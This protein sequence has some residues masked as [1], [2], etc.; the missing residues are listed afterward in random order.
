MD[1]WKPTAQLENLKIRAELLIKIRQFFFERNVLEVETPLLARTTATDVHIQSLEV[2]RMGPALDAIFYLQTSPEFAMKRMLAAGSGAIYQICK[3]FRQ[4]EVSRTHNPEFT[5]LEW[6]QPGYSQ[7]DLINEVESLVSSLLEIQ[8]IP[9]LSY[10]EVFQQQLDFDPHNITL[11]QLNSCAAEYIDVGTQKLSQTDLL[12]LLMDAVVVPQL[13]KNIFVYDFPV[14]QCALA[15]IEKDSDG[16]EVAK[17][18][19]LFCSGIELANGY[20]ELIDSSEQKSRFVVDRSKRQ[21]L[22]LQEYALDSKLIA[23][24]DYGLPNCAG[25][26][27]GIDRLCML[28]IGCTE[29]SEVISFTTDKT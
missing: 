29:I 8:A 15:T 9:K 22:D 26:A 5:M 2:P 10:R 14:D 1:D 7:G 24:L 11:K 25:V 18:F 28:A 13:P 3:A 23:A 16:Q 21:E 27:L 20:Y 17:R 6:Y 12:Q 19:E 4:G